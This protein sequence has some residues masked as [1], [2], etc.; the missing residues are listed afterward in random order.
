MAIALEKLDKSKLYIVEDP[1]WMKSVSTSDAI[2]LFYYNY[3]TQ[4]WEALVHR[5]SKAWHTVHK[6]GPNNKFD[7]CE[8]RLNFSL[9]RP[10]AILGRWARCES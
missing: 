10:L 9:Y 2:W 8:L 3:K 6:L 7:P 1:K 4:A 5:P